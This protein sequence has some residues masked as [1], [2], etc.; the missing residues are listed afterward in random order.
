MVDLRS[1]IAF[2]AAAASLLGASSCALSGEGGESCANSES[3]FNADVWRAPHERDDPARYRMVNHLLQ[4]GALER[5]TESEVVSLLGPPDITP[6]QDEGPSYNLGQ[7]C[8]IGYGITDAWLVVV[9]ADGQVS[10]ARLETFDL[11]KT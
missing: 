1:V 10:S 8:P 7:P 4:S 6:Y 9:I 5:L 3:Q 11:A 2:V